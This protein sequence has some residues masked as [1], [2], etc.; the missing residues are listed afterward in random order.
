MVEGGRRYDQCESVYFFSPTMT[1]GGARWQNWS[2]ALSVMPEAE[3][4]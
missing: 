2:Y 4:P 3:D 1:L